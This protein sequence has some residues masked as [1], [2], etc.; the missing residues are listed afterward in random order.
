MLSRETLPFIVCG[1]F[2]TPDHG[3]IY[4]TVSRGLT[5]AHLHAGRG[6]GLTFPGATRNPLSLHGPWLR[7]D[8]AFAGRGWQPVYCSPEPGRRSQHCAVAAHFVPKG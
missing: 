6:W 2:N 8:Y 7:L 3:I 1:D 4:H 5:D